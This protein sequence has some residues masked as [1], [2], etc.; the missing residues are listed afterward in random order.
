MAARLP[1]RS[2]LP[3]LQSFNADR[4]LLAV[5]PAH[6]FGL[7]ANVEHVRTLVDD[8]SVSIVEDAAQLASAA[9]FAMNDVPAVEHPFLL[10]LTQHGLTVAIHNLRA[11]GI[12]L[13]EQ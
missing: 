6:L 11:N 13:V 4:K 9:A 8:P 5:I 2:L 3:S 10:R 12:S 1:G 7:P